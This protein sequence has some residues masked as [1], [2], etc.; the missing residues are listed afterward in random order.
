MFWPLITLLGVLLLL[1]AGL[2]LFYYLV[3]ERLIFVRF[4]LGDRYRFRFP[5]EWE[6]V[7]LERPDGARLHALHFR[8]ERPRGAVLYFHG[9]TG[10][11]RRWGR[12]APRFLRNGYDVL[13]PDHRGYGKSRGKLSE[14]ALHADARAW[15]DH[16]RGRWPEGP[17]VVYGRSLGSGL[18]VPL[19]A[20]VKPE[21]LVLETPF[22]NLYDVARY[23]LAILPY[24]LLLRYPFRNDRQAHRLR[25]PVLVLHGKRD[26]VVPY[27]SAL[28]L[29]S[30]LS[31]DIHREMVTFPKGTH[32]DLARFKRYGRKL[33]EFLDRVAGSP[34][35]AP[36]ESNA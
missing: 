27:A 32:A 11:L 26:K 20:A 35:F 3:Q 33:R 31:S 16:L 14:Q 19:A 12:Q 21:G 7:F 5:G 4:R 36:P 6:E 9:N 2:C 30:L 24:R 8:T 13:I 15:Y 22:A 23:Y 28:K 25:C 10:S 17:V 29:Y 18:A 34:N 1:Y